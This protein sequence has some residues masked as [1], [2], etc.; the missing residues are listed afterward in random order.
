[1]QEQS[2]A[3]RSGPQHAGAEQPCHLA[4]PGSVSIPPLGPVGC[5]VPVLV[6]MS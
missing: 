5:G 3:C 6:E 2:A 4:C 1:M